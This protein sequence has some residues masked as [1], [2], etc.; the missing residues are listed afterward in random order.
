MLPGARSDASLMADSRDEPPPGAT[1]SDATSAPAVA[2]WELLD[3]RRVLKEWTLSRF[4]AARPTAAPVVFCSD[5]TIGDA[6]K[7]RPV[8]T[9]L[10][11]ARHL[12]ARR[13][14]VSRH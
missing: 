2:T 3:A 6:L 7:V 14:C 1:A 8:G 11:H 5:T 4:L 12:G 10:T 9:L 13:A